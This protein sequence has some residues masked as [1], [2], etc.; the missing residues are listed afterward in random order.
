MAN[1]IKRL[2]E[3]TGLKEIG[4]QA[5][6]SWRAVSRMAGKILRQCSASNVPTLAHSTSCASPPKGGTGALAQVQKGKLL[7]HW[8]SYWRRYWRKLSWPRADHIFRV[9]AVVFFLPD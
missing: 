7:A 8:R 6:K 9:T 1:A 3:K 4:G 2:P 5:A